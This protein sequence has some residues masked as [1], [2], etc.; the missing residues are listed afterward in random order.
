MNLNELSKLEYNDVS[1]DSILDFVGQIKNAK[2]DDDE[3]VITVP[4]E[5][6]RADVVR[7]SLPQKEILMNAP[8]SDGEYFVVPQVVE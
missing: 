4:L 8:K 2:V 5:S 7:P 6:L 1:F 3:D